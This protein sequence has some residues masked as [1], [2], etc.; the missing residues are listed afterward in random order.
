MD[1]RSF[2]CTLAICSMSID[3]SNSLL[4]TESGKVFSVAFLLCSDGLPQ[5]IFPSVGHELDSWR[6]GFLCCRACVRVC[7]TERERE[8][9]FGAHVA[10]VSGGRGSG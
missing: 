5:G 8:R 2:T 3:C 9:K 7:E 4:N 1:E 6:A 10:C